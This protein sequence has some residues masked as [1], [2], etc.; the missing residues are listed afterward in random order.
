MHTDGAGRGGCTRT[1]R[2]QQSQQAV[3]GTDGG[4]SRRPEDGRRT[5][6]ERPEL[7]DSME[8]VGEAAA[9][10][11]G[12]SAPGERAT[13]A[14]ASRDAAATGE[15]E[16]AA[17]D[18]AG[19]GRTPAARRSRPVKDDGG[20]ILYLIGSTMDWVEDDFAAG[21]TFANPNAKGACGCG[22]SFTV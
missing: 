6:P 4:R 16:V 18:A 2:Q 20:S 13:A 15:A 7:A 17:D 5:G 11:E 9:G 8:L 19:R 14:A 1:Q 22:E 12:G 3:L 21:F 10:H